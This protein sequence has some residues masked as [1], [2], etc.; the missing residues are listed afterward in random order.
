MISVVI[1]A[2]NAA[3][4]LPLLLNQLRQKKFEKEIIVVEDGSTDGTKEF[5]AGQKDIVVLSEKIRAGKGA[6]LNRGFM[7]A[8]GDVIAMM[9]ADLSIAP[10]TLV[11][12]TS[13]LN[14][15]DMVIGSRKVDGAHVEIQQPPARQFLGQLFSLYHRL[16]FGWSFL[17]TQCGIKLFKRPVLSAILPLSS[18]GFA[19]DIEIIWKAVKNGFVVKEIPITWIAN[20]TTS[21]NPIVDGFKMAIESLRIRLS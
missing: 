15:A 2:H 20:E 1:P 10:F 17:D 12:L 18:K 5:L 11:E 7:A 21:V 13:E 16:L 8:K 9:D 19:V 14:G 6:A 3:D 4:T